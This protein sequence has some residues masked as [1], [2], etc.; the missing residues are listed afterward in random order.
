[1]AHELTHTEAS[2]LLAVYALDAIDA[3]ERE[4]VESHLVRCGLCRAEVMEH[5][6]VAGLLSSGIA[7]PPASVWDRIAED[8]T[9]TPPPLDLAIVHRMRPPTPV[10]TPRR[11]R[12]PRPRPRP[13][14]GSRRWPT[15]G[16]R[17]VGEA[18]CASERWWR[19]RRSRP[20]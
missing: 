9:D 16:H 20:R 5:V 3:D 2:E 8:I 1:M 15:A 13:R 6:E 4:A 12:R 10:P 18:G 19:R 17:R 11:S 14:P 7:G